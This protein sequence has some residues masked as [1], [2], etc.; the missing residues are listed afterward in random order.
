MTQRAA[1]LVVE[2]GAA[3]I[4]ARFNPGW[5]RHHVA[6]VRERDRTPPEGLNDEQEEKRNASEHGLDNVNDS[7]FIAGIVAMQA[8]K[9]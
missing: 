5:C 2:N 9:Q 3:R 4:V 8:F 6:R 7:R 1:Q